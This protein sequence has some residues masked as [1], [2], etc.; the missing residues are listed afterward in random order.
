MHSNSSSI[1]CPCNLLSCRPVLPFGNVFC[2][3]HCADPRI[4][5]SKRAP[6]RFVAKTPYR[7]HCLVKFAQVSSHCRQVSAVRCQCTS[8]HH[9]SA[10]ELQRTLILGNILILLLACLNQILFH[11]RTA[12]TTRGKLMA[13][14]HHNTE[15]TYEALWIVLMSG[16]M[17]T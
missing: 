17:A 5:L 13:N 8:V 4:L 9:C 14:A 15:N 16:S 2:F 10:Y 12:P 1:V 6:T 11:S 7:F 3:Q